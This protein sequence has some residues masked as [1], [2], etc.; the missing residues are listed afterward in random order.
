[1]EEVVL[2]ETQKKSVFESYILSSFNASTLQDK[3]L[4]YELCQPYLND[5]SLVVYLPSGLCHACFSSLIFS[6]QDQKFPG[7]KVTIISEQED[8]EV[9]RE[10]LSLGIHYS[11][12][13]LPVESISDILVFRSYRG[14]LPIAMEYDLKREPILPLFLSD[15]EKLLRILTHAN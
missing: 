12:E 4:V 9:K 3:V 8:F 13:R 15:N 10:C 1:L 5:S 6:L 2:Q 11:V 14:F 7:D